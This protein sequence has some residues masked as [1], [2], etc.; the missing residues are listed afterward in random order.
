MKRML[1]LAL[2]CCLMAG[3]GCGA[4]QEAAITIDHIQITAEEFEEAFKMSRFAAM[5]QKGREAFLQNYVSRKLMLK[6]AERLGLDK[7][8]QFLGDIQF[9]WEKALLKSIVSRKS[10][11]VVLDVTVSN[12][13][14]RQYYQKHREN[15]FTDKK[16]PEVRD[17][18]QWLLLQ[19]KQSQAI[20]AWADSLRVKA[21]IK[22][23]FKRLGMTE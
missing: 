3:S 2:M 11:E 21:D 10:E 4:K 18:I 1:Y 15:R 13:E 17:Q 5:G 22:I 14:I 19:E 12:Q 7:D 9:F 23:N 8:P 16:L 6:E 20:A